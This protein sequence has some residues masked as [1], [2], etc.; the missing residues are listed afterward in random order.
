MPGRVLEIVC[1]EE[2]SPGASA[3]FAKA[4]PAIAGISRGLTYARAITQRR[5]VHLV[6]DCVVWLN[7]Y[8]GS[9]PFSAVGRRNALT[10]FF[11]IRFLR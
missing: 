2:V 1:G 10:L 7:P 11:A 5:Y 9:P 4:K 6:A 8:S 3:A